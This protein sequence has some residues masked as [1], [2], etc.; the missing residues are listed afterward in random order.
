MMTQIDTLTVV[1]DQASALVRAQVLAGDQRTQ[2]ERAVWDSINRLDLSADDVSAASGLT[3]E[4]VRRI[5]GRTPE[6]VEDL[7]A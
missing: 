6:L 1:R 5:A 3:L 7:A 2:L 4:E